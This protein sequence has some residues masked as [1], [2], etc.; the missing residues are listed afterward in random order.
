MTGTQL[1][2]HPRLQEVSKML[3]SRKDRIVSVLPKGV[4]GELVIKK[5]LVAYQNNPELL[6]CTPASLFH[7]VVEAVTN[8]L[9]IGGTKAQ[10]YVV[11]YGDKATLQIGYK[12]LLEL[13]RRTGQ[14]LESE[15]E[16]VHEG[17]TF[18]FELGDQAK[19]KLIPSLDS[20]RQS[21][22]VT[23]VYARFKLKDGGVVRNVWTAGQVNA[24]RDLYS[25]AY[26]RAESYRKRQ[27]KN[28]QKIDP[29][30]LSP[31]HK[32]WREMAIKTVVR[33]TF[34][35]GRL[36]MSESIQQLIERDRQIE[37]GMTIDSDA[38]FDEVLTPDAR[39]LESPQ[40]PPAPP[41][42][43]QEEL[44]AQIMMDVAEVTTLAGMTAIRE[45]YTN[46][47]DAADDLM[48]FDGLCT[49]AEEDIRQKK[50]EAAN[51]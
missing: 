20:G 19:L 40:V 28:K 9:E 22:P 31:W 14:L 7:S 16:L 18:E 25:V 45:K 50:T 32:N 24:H 13:L 21:R 39:L 17:D 29:Q 44:K 38:S 33:D 15:F 2:H 48:W 41:V 10:A 1:T 26:N 27:V 11:P 30:R 49:N 6:K 36:P 43:T 37:Q 34:G 46:L 51:A 42:P 47:I 5:A 35:R 3:M 4:D 12:G 23:H 8:G